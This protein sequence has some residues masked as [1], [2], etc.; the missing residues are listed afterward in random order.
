MGINSGEE[1]FQMYMLQERTVIDL[2]ARV[3]R[4]LMESTRY[5]GIDQMEW[6][7]DGTDIMVVSMTN[8]GI[9]CFNEKGEQ[10][11]LISEKLYNQAILANRL[12]F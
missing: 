9:M 5:S 7:D 4:E 2:K 6:S 3:N 12:Q 1:G 8:G 11:R 10:V